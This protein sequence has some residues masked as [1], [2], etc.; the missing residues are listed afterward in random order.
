MSV[1]AHCSVHFVICAFLAFSIPYF[2]VSGFC[3]LPVQSVLSKGD[4]PEEW[5]VQEGQRGFGR[6][7]VTDLGES[8]AGDWSQREESCKDSTW[9][10]WLQRG[11]YLCSRPFFKLGW[12]GFCFCLLLLLCVCLFVC[13]LF[14]CCVFVC[15]FAVL[16][17]LF[18]CG[19]LGSKHQLKLFLFILFLFP[20][21]WSSFLQ[22]ACSL[23]WWHINYNWHI[24]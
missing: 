6:A 1:L 15:L 10:Q 8:F 23:T 14:C 18:L 20:L 24:W 7:D 4:K 16:L 3:S 13:L 5:R 11:I 19:W 12:P 21:F 17:L 9:R 2:L 22:Y